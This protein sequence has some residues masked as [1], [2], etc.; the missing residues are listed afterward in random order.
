MDIENIINT[1]NI[2]ELLSFLMQKTVVIPSW[3][4][5][6]KQ[7]DCKLHPI[8]RDKKR[9]PDRF[10]GGKKEPF[11]RIAFDIQR[12]LTNR[13]A[14]LTFGIP[15]KRNVL[16]EHSENKS[17][18]YNC[19]EQIL[20]KNRIDTINLN[21]AK[22]LFSSCEILTIWY[23]VEE[24]NNDYGFESPLKLRCKTFSPMD[25]NTKIYPLFDEYGDMVA[26]SVKYTTKILNNTIT[27][28][29]TYT[30][31]RH[32]Q[33]VNKGL[34]EKT[35]DENISI[36]KIP[37]IYAYREEPI[38][39]N[40]SDLVYDYEETLSRNSNQLRKNTKP[41]FCVFADEAIDYGNEKTENEEDRAI[42]QFPSGSNAE[43]KTLPNVTEN[44]AFHLEKIEKLISK[45]T[46]IPDL[47]VDKLK[48]IQLSG[49]AM[50]R[51]LI[52]AQLKV[53]DESGIF[54][55][56]LS[57]EI[58]VIKSFLKIMLPS[59]FKK[60]IDEINIE[61]II[62]PFRLRDESENIR[63]LVTANGGKPIMSQLTS[64]KLGDYT[65][66]PQEEIKQIN[67]ENSQNSTELTI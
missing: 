4:E 16:N 39:G 3:E 47:S 7:Y 37:C 21:R 32:L 19:I 46:Q 28:F 25:N 17:F 35:I 62:T 61:N 56:F 1:Y 58:S 31:N 63:N 2:V 36:G 53:Y 50:D 5:L 65:L 34:W 15:V 66:N 12:L 54:K 44:L 27:Y 43:Y 64:V 38:W 8:I 48:D 20:L 60:D 14:Q 22:K 55:E 33:F 59:P 11:T 9:F 29:D 41:L 6:K 57:R 13:M 42:I 30:K 51:L 10:F 67:F 26:I 45:V 49:T 24:K 23:A 18:I 40:I 52:D